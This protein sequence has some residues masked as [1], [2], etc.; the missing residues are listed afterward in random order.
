MLDQNPT[1]KTFAAFHV[2]VKELS[3]GDIQSFIK[4]S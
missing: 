4:A 3:F 2:E 1:A